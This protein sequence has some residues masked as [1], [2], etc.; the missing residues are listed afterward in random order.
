[1]YNSEDLSIKF[2]YRLHILKEV[3]IDTTKE[4]RRDDRKE[5]ARSV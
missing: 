1:M 2:V 3:D 5:K 4:R